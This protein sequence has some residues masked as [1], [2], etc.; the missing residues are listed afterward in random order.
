MIWEI[1]WAWVAFGLG[2]AILEIFVPGFLFL[3]FAIGAVLVGV[4][5]AL[6]LGLTLAWLLVGFALVSVIAWAALRRIVGIRQG[7]RKTFDS[8]INE[9]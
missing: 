8:D 3:G 5:V 7:Q 1:W 2:L 6:G 4:V 9:D